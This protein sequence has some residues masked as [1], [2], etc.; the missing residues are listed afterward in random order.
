MQ[1]IVTGSKTAVFPKRN[2]RV[3]FVVFI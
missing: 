1:H 2:L 3:I